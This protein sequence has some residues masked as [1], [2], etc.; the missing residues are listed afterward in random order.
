MK[1][2]PNGLL[3]PILVIFAQKPFFEATAMFSCR[4]LFMVRRTVFEQISPKLKKYYTSLESL[5]HDGMTLFC[6]KCHKNGYETSYSPETAP[7][8][9][10][11]VE[12]ITRFC[13]YLPF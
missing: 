6:K 13:V 10:F 8:F 7:N 4:A 11:K 5:K 3:S 12:K 1:L 9:N 2:S